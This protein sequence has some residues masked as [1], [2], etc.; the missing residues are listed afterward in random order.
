M[1]AGRRKYIFHRWIRKRERTPF[2]LGEISMLVSA[3]RKIVS[4]TSAVLCGFLFAL[5][6]YLC[7]PVS[8]PLPLFL[9]PLSLSSSSLYS[10]S[11]SSFSPSHTVIAVDAL[12]L[13]NAPNDPP[14]PINLTEIIVAIATRVIGELLPRPE[15]EFERRSW[16]FYC[17]RGNRYSMLQCSQVAS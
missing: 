10:S 9:F 14:R 8:P 4:A 16:F 2:P 15:A 11:A 3:C 7:E 12:L 5:R 17:E 1:C 13:R 6:T